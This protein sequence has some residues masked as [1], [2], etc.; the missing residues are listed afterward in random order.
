MDSPKWSNGHGDCD[1]E[2]LTKKECT[3]Y[4]MTCAGYVSMGLCADGAV[5]KGHEWT[6]G[7][8]FNNPEEH[9]CACGGG[10]GGGMRKSKC[11]TNEHCAHGKFCDEGF[12]S[13]GLG[14]LIDCSD[15]D[16]CSESYIGDGYSDCEDQQYGCDLSCYDN[17]GGDC[18]A[19]LK[20]E[21]DVL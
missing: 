10:T 8:A 7:S 20:S 12:C 6:T 11:T 9:C 2:R 3:P 1:D 19:P 13:F 15:N 14:L 5:I 18:A 17:D 21:A 16:C 4:G